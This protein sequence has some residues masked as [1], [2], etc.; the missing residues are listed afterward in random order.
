MLKA[1]R[2]GGTRYFAREAL[3]DA[4]QTGRSQ[5]WLSASKAQAHEAKGAIVD[6][7]RSA[8]DIELRGDPIV[9]PSRCALAQPD[10]DPRLYFLGTNALTAQGY[11]GN[12]IFD[13]Y[14][15]V[16][17]FGILR[18][19]ASGMALHKRL[20]QTYL[21]SPSA[22]SHEA[23]PFW[24]GSHFNRGRPKEQHIKLDVSHA[25]LAGGRLCEDGQWRQIVTVEDA[26]AAGCDLYD[27]DQLRLEYSA[28]EFA[29]L[30]MCLFIDDGQSVFS[31][32]ALH[33]CMVDAW[34]VWDDFKPFAN[35]PL[36][37]RGVWVGYDPSN[38]GDSAA[39]V[40]VAPPVIVG[41]KF[42]VLEKMQF[43]GFGYEEQA[44]A[45]KK[46]GGRYE[47][48]F[49]GIDTTG[50]GLAV[51]QL[52]KKWYPRAV[53]YQYSVELKT[54]MVLKAIS[55]IGK[56]RLEFDAGWTDVVSSFLSIKKT[57]TKSNRQSTFESGRSEETSHADLAWAIM[58]CLANEP[59][60]GGTIGSTNKGFVEIG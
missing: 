6:F 18:K 10:E 58:H 7:A 54:R 1:R 45:I 48:D 22:L 4:L 24:S 27:L 60:E 30:L 38:T 35:R 17:K 29:Q 57:M 26:V 21:S 46:I 33:A 51:Y 2:I 47:V 52:V 34:E 59:L 16:H 9:I 12:F 50:I 20:R 36:G 23:Y 25:A 43:R 37:G 13:E 56:G 44:E 40:V 5:I 8:A 55:V 49:I 42:R 39:L 41:G 53:A 19:V 11:G 28:E 31:F 15:W 3:D 14:F 32:A